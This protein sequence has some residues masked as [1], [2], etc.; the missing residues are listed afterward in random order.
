[1][2]GCSRRVPKRLARSA[3]GAKWPA[4]IRSRS[5]ASL[6][7]ST[8]RRN[9]S[10]RLIARVTAYGHGLKKDAFRDSD[11][12]GRRVTS[13]CVVTEKN[14]MS[15]PPN[16]SNRLPPMSSNQG[17][18]SRLV[19]GDARLRSACPPG[20]PQCRPVPGRRVRMSVPTETTDDKGGLFP[21]MRA[22]IAT[23]STGTVPAGKPSG[24]APGG[25]NGD[26]GSVHEHPMGYVHIKPVARRDDHGHGCAFVERLRR[27]SENGRCGRPVSGHAPDQPRAAPEFLQPDPAGA[28]I[29]P[30]RRSRRRGRILRHPQRTAGKDSPEGGTHHRGWRIDQHDAPAPALRSLRGGRGVSGVRAQGVR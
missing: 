27:V 10:A 6:P 25:M 9:A 7:A 1:M 2:R 8:R 29:R 11:R 17:V 26:R 3:R 24:E 14:G 12:C 30:Y 19:D 4:S 15:S 22:I 13:C 20:F 23:G 28:R 16:G 18:S 21:L 5:T